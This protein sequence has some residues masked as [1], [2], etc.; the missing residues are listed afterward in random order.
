MEAAER[1][2]HPESSTSRTTAYSTRGP[3]ESRMRE[4][5]SAEAAADCPS[6]GVLSYGER[7]M[8]LYAAALDPSLTPLAR[9]VLTVINHALGSE[10]GVAWPS[11]ATIASLLGCTEKWVCRAVTELEQAGY[12]RVDR[13]HRQRVYSLVRQQPTA[14]QRVP[15]RAPIEPERVP[16]R[17]P[18]E[19]ERVPVSAPIAPA[20][21]ERV[22]VRAPKRVP[23]PAP[24]TVNT[25]TGTPETPTGSPAGGAPPPKAHAAPEVSLPEDW[26]P[27][28][29]MIAACVAAKGLSVARVRHET[30]QFRL[31]FLGKPS[32]KWSR[33]DLAWKKW[34]ANEAPGGKY[35]KPEPAAPQGSGL[36]RPGNRGLIAPVA[37]AEQFG[38]S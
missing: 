35:Y 26:A 38:W 3:S 23:D 15:V 28:E 36:M 22:P 14:A 4:T 19:P 13:S 5:A 37:D 25:G 12:V 24:R 11:Q 30:E 10:S 1:Q 27:T 18:I 7:E 33:W 20:E 2:S 34:M 16:V 32:I 9:R 31:H 17:A 29:A 6:P 8:V 21:P